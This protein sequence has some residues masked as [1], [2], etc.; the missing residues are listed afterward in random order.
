MKLPT[1]GHA[2][3]INNLGKEF[4]GT[5]VDVEVLE[6]TLKTVGFIT[7]VYTDCTKQVS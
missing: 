3:I 1:L 4:K 2:V 6:E 5:K 7:H